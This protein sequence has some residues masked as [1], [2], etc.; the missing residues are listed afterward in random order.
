[1]EA[2]HDNDKSSRRD[3][4]QRERIKNLLFDILFMSTI[5]V[6]CVGIFYNILKSPTFDGVDFLPEA[7]TK[8]GN[9]NN[10]GNYEKV[11]LLLYYLIGGAILVTISVGLYGF[12]KTRLKRTTEQQTNDEI[13]GLAQIGEAGIDTQWKILKEGSGQWGNETSLVLAA[14]ALESRI[15]IWDR[16]IHTNEVRLVAEYGNKDNKKVINLFHEPSGFGKVNDHYN[17]YDTEKKEVITVK[18]D[19]RCMFR[20]LAHGHFGD[21]NEFKRVLE[22]M[23]KQFPNSNAMRAL[24][25]EEH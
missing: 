12:Y 15:V 10:K 8:S 9:K 6:V 2:K 20:A 24:L 13:I 3:A 11:P 18:G 4:Y 17:F 19:G 1:M 25:P 22:L 7:T 14:E 5:I 23:R 21:E 16:D